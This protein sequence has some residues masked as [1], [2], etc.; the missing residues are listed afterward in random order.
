[1]TGLD[2]TLPRAFDAARAAARA[3]ELCA[4]GEV[5]LDYYWPL[6][7]FLSDQGVAPRERIDALIETRR[8]EL[9]AEPNVR[10]RLAAQRRA[11]EAWIALA[12]ELDLPLVVHER[13]AWADAAAVLAES[14]LPADRVMIHCFSAGVDALRDAQVRGYW[15]SL[16]ASMT[17]RQPYA[18]EAREIDLEQAL[19]E[20]DAP[21]QT[22]IKGLWK[23]ALAEAQ[24][25]AAEQPL[26]RRKRESWTRAEKE[27]LFR[28]LLD[29]YLPGLEFEDD[30]GRRAPAAEYFQ[31]SRRRNVNETAFVRCAAVELARAQ[32][33][34]LAR[35]AETTTR[36]AA[37]LFG[38]DF[39]D[40][41]DS[42]ET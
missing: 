22:P 24:R 35:V 31:S 16:P 3:G 37:R 19:I 39:D 15:V 32:G 33:A 7:G 42:I 25:R 21:Y 18:D 38:L 23:R 6:V 40:G 34:P 10:E 17:Y 14:R 30:A 13:D 1:M 11:F 28:E 36:N 26:T 9:L 41:V 5:G 8:E 2:A 29:E 27:R 20:T 4:I 12:E